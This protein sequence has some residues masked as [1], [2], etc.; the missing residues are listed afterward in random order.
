MDG[1]LTCHWCHAERACLEW[2]INDMLEQQII[3]GKPVAHKKIWCLTSL[4]SCWNDRFL[5][6]VGSLGQ[7]KKQTYFTPLVSCWKSMFSVGH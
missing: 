7:Q 4:M 6:G 2:A 5:V 3:G 1:L